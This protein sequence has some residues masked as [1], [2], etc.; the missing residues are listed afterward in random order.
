MRKGVISLEEAR[1]NLNIW[2]KAERAIAMAQSYAIGGRSLTRANLAE[3]A[4]R[5]TYWENKV[6]ELE[7]AAKG[8]RKR[9]MKQFIPRDS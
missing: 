2:L 8:K 1:K 4:K 9:R 3:V 6:A 7:M 5:I